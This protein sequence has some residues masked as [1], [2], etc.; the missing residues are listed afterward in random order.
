MVEEDRYKGH[1]LLLELWQER[2]RSDPRLKLVIV[3][4][5]SDR[6]RIEEKSLSLGLGDSV[7][8]TGPIPD[9][10]LHALYRDCEF[11]VMPSS[12]EGFGLVYLEAMRAGKA[13]I[14]ACGAAAEVIED[15]V[16]G[17]LVNPNSPQ[18]VSDAVQALASSPQRARQMGAAGYQRFLAKFTSDHFAEALLAALGTCK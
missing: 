17:L 8:F 13:C 5:G 3:G 4:D 1:D 12:G 14:A 2:M 9:G 16:T 18:E 6:R 11:F 7:I 10:Q 15:G